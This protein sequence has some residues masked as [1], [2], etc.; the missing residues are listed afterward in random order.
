MHMSVVVVQ[1]ICAQCILTSYW[2]R[3]TGGKLEAQ[4]GYPIYI[5]ILL[6]SNLVTVDV[7]LSQTTKHTCNQNMIKTRDVV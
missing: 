5:Y 2:E 7:C 4:V 6:R 3:K 1:S